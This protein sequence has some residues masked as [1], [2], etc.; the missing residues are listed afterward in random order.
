L[1]KYDFSY[2]IVDAIRNQFICIKHHNF[3][4]PEKS[5][6][7]NFTQ[8]VAD[9][10]YLNKH[11][12]AVNFYLIHDKYTLVPA[13]FFDKKYAKEYFK[14]NHIISPDDEVHF[15]FSEKA[16][17]FNVF[18]Y[19]TELTNFLVNH[20]PEIRLFHS[21]Y[22]F[23]NYH[24][25]N[26][27]KGDE[28]TTIAINIKHSSFDIMALRKENLVLLNTFEFKAREDAVYFIISI[29]KKL[30]LD[31]NKVQIKLQG[32]TSRQDKIYLYLKDYF[33]NISF[34]TKFQKEYPFKE[35]SSYFLADILSEI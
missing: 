12:K 28:T 1:S 23:M 11:Y 34:T 16:N 6:L 27:S 2:V 5:L 19:P 9:D 33:P 32:D 17:L 18:V 10:V 13:E 31:F 15:T 14:F 8:A 21:T 3:E 29:I 7:E 26:N 25:N 24:L 22:P 35:V 30:N 20:F 4:D